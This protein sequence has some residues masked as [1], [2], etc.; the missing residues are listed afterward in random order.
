VASEPAIRSSPFRS[1]AYARALVVRTVRRL[2]PVVFGL[3]LAAVYIAAAK[4][5]LTMAFVAAQVSPVWPPTGIAIAAVLLLGYRVWPGIW[6]GA[7]VAN[8]GAHEPL[9]TAVGIAVGNTL[10]P[11]VAAWLLHRALDFQAALNRLRDVLGFVGLAALAATTVSATMGVT[12]LCLGRVQ[13]WSHYPQLWWIWWLGDAIGALVVTPVLLTYAGAPWRR[14]RSS[15]VVETVGLLV[16]SVVVCLTVFAGRL[17]GANSA[18]PLQYLVF[19]LVIWGALRVGQVGTS[20]VTLVTAAIATWGSIHGFGPFTRGNPHESLVLLQ[21]FLG[22]VATTGLVLGA[23]MHER[24][25]AEQRRTTD[26]AATRGLAQSVSLAEAGQAILRAICESLDWDFGA[27]WIV[28]RDGNVLRCVET[29]HRPSKPVPVFAAATRQGSFEPGVGLPGR[30]WKSG[31]PAWIPD[32]VA[33]PNFPR[34]PMAVASDF[35]GAFGVPVSLG[36]ET[37]GAIEFF[38]REIQRPDLALLES[39]RAIGSQIGFFIEREEILTRERQARSEAEAANRAKDEFLAMLGHELRNPLGAIASAVSLLGLIERDART[40]QP[41]EI[42]GRQVGNLTRLV[43]DL[44]DVA[45]VT[46]G[47]VDLKREPVDLGRLVEAS[48]STLQAPGRNGSHQFSVT[49]ASTIVDA[50]P[51]RL[52]QIV[53]NLLD[54][55][56]KYTPPGGQI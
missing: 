54:N 26:L 4:L 15:Q 7:L 39:M 23:A 2:S 32:V 51:V 10:E 11:L 38:S 1:R 12:S 21:L 5:G 48:V 3:A 43:D 47:R 52:G 33:D 49:T 28:D 56:V 20:T 34:A 16:V 46:S 14:W 37:L 44:L 35:H 36:A 27:L 8:V 53:M 42:M 17:G 31:R 25:V 19:P 13:S 6:L 9:G 45:R 18:Y 55:A 22:V 24:R 40:A 29:W 50:D 41:L 30:V